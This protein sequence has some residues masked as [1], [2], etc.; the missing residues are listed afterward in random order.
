[1]S[2][3]QAQIIVIALEWGEDQGRIFFESTLLIA[4]SVKQPCKALLCLEYGCFGKSFGPTLK[5]TFSILQTLSV[6]MKSILDEHIKYFLH[7]ISAL[8]AN[9]KHNEGWPNHR[10]SHAKHCREDKES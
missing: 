7:N 10:I 8:I 2:N 3:T 1:M 5:Y 4:R 9:V 6:L